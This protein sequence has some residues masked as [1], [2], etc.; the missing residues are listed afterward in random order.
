ME[1]TIDRQI[2]VSAII[3]G[4]LATFRYR[5]P[6]YLKLLPYM[7]LLGFITE[8]AGV[9]MA[10]QQGNNAALFNAFSIVQFV[11][12]TYFFYAATPG[13][14]SRRI[15][16]KL[17]YIIPAVC[18]VNI[19]FIQGYNVFHTYTYTLCSLL[20]MALGIMYFYSIFKSSARLNLLREPS[21]WISTGIIFFF[22]SS[23]SILGIINYMS[24]LSRAVIN[25]S[26][27]MLRFLNSML[28]ILFIIA[29]ICRISIRKSTPS[30]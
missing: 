12:F 13:Q 5:H 25:N 2:L 15:T 23:V 1:M 11:F 10:R 3:I 29:F 28:Y 9:M 27:H 30:S 21:F 7:L 4:F 20:M 19:F 8:Y 24:V 18:L 16:G 17:L 22:T 14:F 26:L 6:A